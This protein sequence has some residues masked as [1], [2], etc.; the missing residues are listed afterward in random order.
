[1]A[2][3]TLLADPAADDD[4]GARDRVRTWL[5]DHGAPLMVSGRDPGEAPP[6]LEVVVAEALVLAHR[7]STVARVLPVLFWLNRDRLDWARL[8]TEATARD[9][10][11]ALGFFLELTGELAH[12]PNLGKRAQ[13]LLDHRRRRQQHFF[14]GHH[15]PYALAAAKENSPP[16]AQRW[17]YFMNM[18][19][20]GFASAF[21][22]H[23]S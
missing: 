18:P 4:A 7:D 9:E 1:V 12:D 3:R 17:G 15:G 10:R 5:A 13:H 14:S 20:D 22:K 23:V 21:A 6:P 8:E 19:L 11:H 16:F 2:L